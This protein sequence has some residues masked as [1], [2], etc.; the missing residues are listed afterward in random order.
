MV[1]AVSSC[2]LVRSGVSVAVVVEVNLEIVLEIA[3]ESEAVAVGAIVELVGFVGGVWTVRSRGVD[4]LTGEE[5]MPS[6]AVLT[7][8]VLVGLAIV[9]LFTG[10]GAMPVPGD[11]SITMIYGWI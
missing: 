10:L 4:V 5:V 8:I 7:G 9:L 1:L 6:A 3:I 2:W 11:C